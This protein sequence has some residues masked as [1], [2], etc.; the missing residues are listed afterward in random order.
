MNSGRKITAIL[1]M[2]L[3]LTIQL[4]GCRENKNGGE[5]GETQNKETVNNYEKKQLVIGVIGRDDNLKEKVKE[6]TERNIGCEIIIKEYCRDENNNQ[7]SYEEALEWLKNDIMKDGSIDMVSISDINPRDISGYDMF[8]NLYK[9]MEKDTLLSYKNYNDNILK[10]YEDKGSLMAVPARFS[11]SCLAS[12]KSLLGEEAL[13][14]EKFLEIRKNNRDK[15][16]YNNFLTVSEELE[17]LI[18]TNISY[19][20]NMNE[21][22]CR[23]NDGSFEKIL[24]IASEFEKEEKM[25]VTAEDEIN[26][27][28][29]KT[30][31]SN[32][33]FSDAKEYGYYFAVFGENFN[34]TGYPAVDGKGLRAEICGKIFALNK[35]SENKEECWKF[36]RSMFSEQ[37]LAENEQAS[38]FSVDLDEMEKQ[39]NEICL[40]NALDKR[41]ES[42]YYRQF[43]VSSDLVLK[44]PYISENQKNELKEMILSVNVL[45]SREDIVCKIVE[46]EAEAYFNGSKS[47]A[48]VSEAVQ[49][50]VEQY[51]NE[52]SK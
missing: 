13:T 32:H 19:F 25:Q 9:Y 51:I 12:D 27:I 20:L 7:L 21:K 2:L 46:E 26:L 23:F 52:K 45:K 43:H 31:F 18:G 37:L 29:G 50:R 11:I 33:L 1:L 47:A 36:I 24:E 15:K 4:A 30:L 16:I 48:E 44:Y 41:E 34:I 3:V 40:S 28:K 5:A 49:N 39:L 6:Y 14:L 8:E 22:E 17:N 10:L 42:G 35:N 38:G